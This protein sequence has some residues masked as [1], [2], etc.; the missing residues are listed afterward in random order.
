VEMSSGQAR[1]GG[2][3]GGRDRDRRDDRRSDRGRR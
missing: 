2:G 3:G 1:G